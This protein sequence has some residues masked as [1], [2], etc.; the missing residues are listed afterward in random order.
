MR[1]LDFILDSNWDAPFFK[2]LARNDT[3]SAPGHQAGMVFPKDLRLFLPSLNE[4]AIS[5]ISPTTDRHLAG[6]LFD[7]KVHVEDRPV[8]YQFQTWGG[9]R[10]PE[11]RLTE[12]LQP[13]RNRASEGDLIIFQRRADSLDFFRLILVRQ[14]TPEYKEVEGIVG[15]RKWG[16]LFVD[17]IPVTQPLLEEAGKEI[18][19]LVLGKFEVLRSAIP[20]TESRQTRIA[21]SS[22]FREL[23]R[24]QYGRKCAVS[25][26]SIATPSP[27]MHEVVSAHVVPVSE[28]GSDDVRNGLALTQT[29]HWA[30]DRGLFGIT[31]D[32]KVYVPKKVLEISTNKFLSDFLNKSI[33]EASNK[34]MRVH[35]DALEWH[36]ENVVKQWD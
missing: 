34:G 8:R 20:R 9:T 4:S 17:E 33:L 2:R 7:G 31:R 30:F 16:P 21:R 14:R 18:S 35:P 29:L 11:S 1:F 10:R 13:L 5:E 36:M 25:G 3:G 26:I 27:T 23:V 19:N 32:R 22:V 28:G 15:G 24:K 12:G 6:S